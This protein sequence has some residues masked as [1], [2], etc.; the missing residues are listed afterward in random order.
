MNITQ[1]FGKVMTKEQ[2]NDEPNQVHLERIDIGG[3]DPP[4]LK[5]SDVI[6]RLEE[7]LPSI[8]IVN[9][10]VDDTKSYFHINALPLGD[11]RPFEVVSKEYNNVKWKGC[12]ITVQEARP[13]LLQRLENERRER[14]ATIHSQSLI[15]ASAEADQKKEP[16]PV[17]LRRRLRIRQKY[18]T[19]A[20]RVDTKPCETADWDS[21]GKIVRQMRTRRDR[22]P[23]VVKKKKGVATVNKTQAF[24]SRA[25]HLR[26]VENFMDA[27]SLMACDPGIRHEQK[28]FHG[29]SVLADD[30]VSSGAGSEDSSGEIGSSSKEGDNET[31]Y[32]ERK[33]YDWSTDESSGDDAPAVTS[34]HGEIENNANH[35]SA[36][37][38]T[39]QQYLW[40]SDDSE[41]E[42]SA[43]LL[44][45]KLQPAISEFESA[46]DFDNDDDDDDDDDDELFDIA[47]NETDRTETADDDLQRDV[48]SNL[49]VLT[50]LFPDLKDATPKH[51]GKTH[52]TTVIGWK[53]SSM[54]RYDP[55]KESSQQ[56]ELK[57]ENR[58]K[59][60]ANDDNE[61]DADNPSERNQGDTDGSDSQGDADCSEAD[62]KL[63][64]SDEEVSELP[65][66][67][68]VVQKSTIEGNVY[69]ESQLEE[70]FRHARDSGAGG[71]FQVAAL[72][73][74]QPEELKVKEKLKQDVSGTFS[75][76][77]KVES[78]PVDE[79]TKMYD[80][81]PLNGQAEGSARVDG[82][83]DE[84]M[85]DVA[86]DAKKDS[87]D[88][89]SDLERPRR[90][91]LILPDSVVDHYYNKFFELND[92]LAILQDPDGFR[93]DEAVKADWHKERHDLT[94]D[95]KRKRKFALSRLQKNNKFRK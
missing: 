37:L 73:G 39:K 54:Q 18:G 10:M 44:Q 43:P 58:E 30:D 26:F 42:V 4:F 62:E 88:S 93:N 83:L 86:I 14:V 47:Y 57:E 56:F 20:H 76:G 65:S 81:V 35:H 82:E 80:S 64:T 89:S 92:G 74:E 78:S 5:P 38:G 15:R 41:D 94:Q 59:V 1:T 3:L 8:T 19:E 21:F 53:A 95:W 79:G 72:F 91:G 9:P 36:S 23:N 51:V 67:V 77:F 55:T 50:Q 71:G 13:H 46:V 2:H 27:P 49:N 87:I 16:E 63:G 84:H 70:V 85:H 17:V 90:R 33:A 61:N 7:S 22:T 29:A 60:T 11:K 34:I 28:E 66:V 48:E 40:S 52:D 6:R 68:H 75:F 24:Y 25:V 31:I 45:I 69:R 12:R 32:S